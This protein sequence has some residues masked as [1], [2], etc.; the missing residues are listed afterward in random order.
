MGE[1]ARGID[2]IIPYPA[3]T[4]PAAAAVAATT[5]GNAADALGVREK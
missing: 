3:G 2:A 5:E 4:T 1:S